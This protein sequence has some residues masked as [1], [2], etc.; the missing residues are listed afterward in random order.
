MREQR[1]SPFTCSTRRRPRP[2]RIRHASAI[3]LA[4]VAALGCVE[5]TGAVLG[6]RPGPPVFDAVGPVPSATQVAWQAQELTAFLHFG[7]NTFTNREQGDGTDSPTVFRPTSLDARQW[8]AALRRAGVRQALFT[9]KHHDGFCLWP[10]KCTSYTVAASPYNA[11]QGDVVREL[12][13]AA[14]EANIRVGLALSPLDRHDPSYGTPAYQAVFECQLTE[15][16]TAYGAVDEIWMWQSPAPNAFDGA[17]IR[18]LVHRLQPQTLVELSNIP[19]TAANDLRTVGQSLPGPPPPMDES[20]VQSP[21]GAGGTPMWIPAEAVYSIRPGWFWHAAEDGQV[22]TAA[23]LLALYIDTVGRNSVLRLN[24]PPDARGLLPDPDVAALEQ[25]GAAVAGLFR[26]N[27]AAG[28]AA[29]ADSVFEDAPAYAA[30]SA[31]DG[32]LDTFWAAAAG[33]TSARLEVDLGAGRSFGVVS[34]QEPIALG[35][36][37]RQH[38][39]E[40]RTNGVWTTIA[41]GGPIGQRKLYRLGPVTADR[42]AL[43]ITEARGAPAISELGLYDSASPDAAAAS[44]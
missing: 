42:V 27:V 9:A 33:R 36:R 24:V 31:F 23:D 44:P 20:S 22:R 38:R 7:V 30:A 15:L 17:A 8:I 41:S 18:D 13:D 14:H 32:K 1:T 16:L 35:E 10:S 37:A 19:P 2:R 34:I 43:T 25:L 28:N 4:A 3:A 26:A 6:P 12:V 39:L 29:T 40:A 21:P 5:K 11:G